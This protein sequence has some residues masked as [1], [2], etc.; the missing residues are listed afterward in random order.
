MGANVSS[1]VNKVQNEIISELEQS[2]GANASVICGV[3]VGDIILRRANGCS[4]ENV[5][6]CTTNAGAA[7]DAVSSASAKAWA[8]SSQAQKTSFPLPGINASSSIQDVQASVRNIVK[9]KCEANA[10]TANQIATGNLILEDCTNSSI[11][12]INAGSAQANCAI[13][14]VMESVNDTYAKSAQEQKTG[15]LFGDFGEMFQKGGIYLVLFYVI[16]CCICCFLL[17]ILGVGG[18][19]F[20]GATTPSQLSQQ[21]QPSLELNE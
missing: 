3:S 20:S 21:S 15:D 16:C 11:K 7:L 18:M 5:N 17:I 6:R 14:T 12:N 10:L 4:V 1:A 9:Q 8:E 13:R 19:M 2:A